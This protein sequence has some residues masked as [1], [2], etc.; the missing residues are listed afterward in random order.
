MATQSLPIPSPA[1]R[2]FTLTGGGTGGHLY[3]L[4][5]LASELEII[6]LDRGRPLALQF[7]GCPGGYASLLTANGMA[8]RRIARAQPV[9]R[10][11]L[12]NFI[13]IPLFLW[14]F[15]QALAHLYLFMPDLV[16]SK[17]GPG[18]LAV[19]LA[20]RFYRIPV[21]IHDSD[22]YP[23]LTSRL[24]ARFAER[25]YLGFAEAIPNFSYARDF[26]VVGVPLRRSLFHEVPDAERAK[27]AL[28]FDPSVP[29][30]LVLGGS[31]GARRVN[32]YIFEALPELLGRYQVLHQLGRANYASAVEAAALRLEGLPI[33]TTDRYR[34]VEYF[35]ND[36][37]V[38]Y[39]A[40]D[41]VISRAGSIIFE[42]A[43]FARPSIL[44]PLPEA[45]GHQESNAR[46]YALHGACSVIPD[47]EVTTER[48]LVEVEQIMTSDARYA[49]FSRAAAS[50]ARPEA[51]SVIARDMLDCPA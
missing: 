30:I 29:L 28:E 49:A 27:R 47:G 33:R 42:I 35:E 25:V 39:A 41:L 24:S 48:L 21:Y 18:A 46:A 11:S 5:A 1:A 32:E 45:N 38:A 12:V 13:E 23:G 3:P 4:I 44:I 17:G 20:A 51:A 31:Q 14:S 2:R 40:S 26:R 19:V 22:S 50:F 7:V 16:F 37:K 36:I 10:F 34:P 43:A 8:V 15:L 6:A 9:P